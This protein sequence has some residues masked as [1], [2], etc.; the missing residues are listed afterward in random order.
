MWSS[1][2]ENENDA[3]YAARLPRVFNIRTN[4]RCRTEWVFNERFRLTSVKMEYIL[5]N[6]GNLLQHET[7]RNHSLS[8]RQQLLAALHWLGTGSQYHAV[9]DM[10]CISKAT[11]CRAVHAVVDAIYDILLQRLVIWPNDMLAVVRE[12]NRISRLPLVTGAMDGTL[13]QIDAPTAN[14]PAYVD[15]HGNHSINVMA[16]CGPDYQFYYISANWPGSVHDARVLRNSPLYRR[17][18]GGWRPFPNGIIVGD[19]AYPLKEWLI[20]PIVRN[21]NDEAEQRFL[22][23]HRQARRVIEQAFG[24]MK[25]K[26]P[27][28]KLLRLNPQLSAKVVMCC[29]ALCNLSREA[30]EA[31][32][33]GEGLQAD[34][35]IDLRPLDAEADQVAG[36]GV[37]RLQEIIN[38]FR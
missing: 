10:H 19:S 21:P 38:H 33:N 14:E 20:P 12:F 25:E 2:S 32:P 34:N 5:E 4:F 15:R 24:I 6:I 18:E 22:R 26:F 11:V 8:P 27:C 28:L 36:R 13:I 30:N 7:E 35:N 16:V 37:N 17:M 9:A 3:H 29:A 1:D 31:L 23:S